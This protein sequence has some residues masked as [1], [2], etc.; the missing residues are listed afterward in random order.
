[1]SNWY[2]EML[3]ANILFSIFKNF[4]EEELE[5]YKKNIVLRNNG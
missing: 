2:R 5:N 1:M 4:T 3:R